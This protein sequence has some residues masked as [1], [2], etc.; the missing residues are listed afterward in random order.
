MLLGETQ[1]IP[2]L[3]GKVSISVGIILMQYV[4]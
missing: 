1:V 3:H 2:V 4:L